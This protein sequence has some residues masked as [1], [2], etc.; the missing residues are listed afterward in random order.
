MSYFDWLSMIAV[1]DGYKRCDYQKL[2][3]ALMDTEFWWVVPRDRNRA[4]DGLELREL[5]E[6][7]TGEG[8]EFG[9]PCSIL[10]MLLALAIRCNDEIMYDPDDPKR[11][12][13]WF[14]MM[15]EN[16]ELDRFVNEK[17]DREAVRDILEAF[18][19]RKVDKKVST[20]LFPIPKMSTSYRKMELWYQMNYY[21]KWRFSEYF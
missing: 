19:G 8:C 17:F 15:I 21:L 18:C 16:L 10:E 20:W 14:W 11:A 5:Y 4:E 1:P 12:D 9:G 3:N 13:K 6:E 7:E 2:L